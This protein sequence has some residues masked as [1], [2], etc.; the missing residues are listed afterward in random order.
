MVFAWKYMFFSRIRSSLYLDEYRK[1]SCTQHPDSY[2]SFILGTFPS[3]GC[4]ISL[5][6]KYFSA[7]IPSQASLRDKP[8]VQNSANR[9][10]TC[11]KQPKLC[12]FHSFSA[13]KSQLNTK[14]P[15]SIVS[16]LEGFDGGS[17]RI[18]T[19]DLPGMNQQF[20]ASVLTC[21][22]FPKLS[23]QNTRT[24]KDAFS[25]AS[26]PYHHSTMSKV[27]AAI[28]PQPRIDFVVN[29]SCRITAARIIVITTLSLS[30]GTTLEAS[31]ICSAL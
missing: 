10:K 24:K 8:T 15:S 19:I 28:N 18:R 11:S 17:R 9:L 23:I 13:Q 16:I 3:G 4:K 30:T 20:Y 29:C 14:N 26:L 21:R 5:H 2:S 25:Q 12:L 6:K 22:I 1:R 27:P 31:P 7:S